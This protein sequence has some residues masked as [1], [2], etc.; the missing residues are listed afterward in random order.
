MEN[1]CTLKENSITQTIL[2]ENLKIKLQNKQ[3]DLGKCERWKKQQ[4]PNAAVRNNKMKIF[5]R[6]RKKQGKNGVGSGVPF[7]VIQYHSRWKVF[8]FSGVEKSVANANK[9]S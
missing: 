2:G 6:A 4:M 9:S 3:L 8:S 7:Y 5:M 1:L